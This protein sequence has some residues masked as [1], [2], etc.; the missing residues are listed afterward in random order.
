M[1]GLLLIEESEQSI[2]RAQE[3]PSL[4]FVSTTVVKPQS[5]VVAARLYPTG[6]N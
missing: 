5:R 1:E 6:M 2:D 3:C 4:S